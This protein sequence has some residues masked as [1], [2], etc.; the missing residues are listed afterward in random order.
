MVTAGITDIL[1]SGGIFAG[2]VIAVDDLQVVQ[3]VQR[4]G[5]VAHHHR[6]H[7]ARRSGPN[8]IDG[9]LRRGDRDRVCG[10]RLEFNL[11]NVFEGQLPKLVLE[12]VPPASWPA[13][14]PVCLGTAGTAG[15]G[16]AAPAADDCVPVGLN[17]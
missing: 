9:H 2:N 17:I 5:G 10:H 3:R 11:G 8:G 15:T 13:A 16:V 7:G 14:R 12:L 1:E 6:R 4:E